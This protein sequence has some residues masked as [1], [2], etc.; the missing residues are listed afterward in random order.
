[1]EEKQHEY[2][3]KTLLLPLCIC[4]YFLWWYSL[5]DLLSTFWNQLNSPKLENVWHSGVNWWSEVMF[6]MKPTEA[7]FAG[8]TDSFAIAQVIG[9]GEVYYRCV[10]AATTPVPNSMW[11]PGA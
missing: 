9:R 7:E 10:A 6:I 8:K 5:E 3:C 4:N 2:F 11:E 1:M